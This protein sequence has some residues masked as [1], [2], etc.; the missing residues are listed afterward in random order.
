M[1]RLFKQQQRGK[2]GTS[3][4]VSSAEVEQKYCHCGILF[5]HVFIPLPPPGVSKTALVMTCN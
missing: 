5:P 1:H 3:I 4:T 2:N